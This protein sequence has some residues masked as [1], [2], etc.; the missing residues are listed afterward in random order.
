MRRTSPSLSFDPVS[1]QVL[2]A[3]TDGKLK[4][5]AVPSG[6]LVAVY[7]D[8]AGGFFEFA[9][10]P[11]GNLI[12]TA[13]ADGLVKLWS[14]ETGALLH[15]LEGHKDRLRTVVFS[16]DGR[17][18]ASGGDD[19]RITLWDVSTLEPVQTLELEGQVDALAFSADGL[20][21]ASGGRFIESVRL[22]D[23]STGQKKGVL[24]S[25]DV[26]VTYLAYSPDNRYL[27]GA[28][29]DGRTILWEVETGKAAH[30]LEGQ[31]GRG[32]PVVFSADG[33]YFATVD[34]YDD[35]YYLW[36]AE[37][38][39]LR[40]TFQGAG[41]AFVAVSLN[42]DGSLLAGGISPTDLNDPNQVGVWDTS[43]GQ[44]VT[45][46]GNLPIGNLL[47]EFSPDGR[48]IA[49]LVPFNLIQLWEVGTEG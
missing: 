48:R 35:R 29:R 10:H 28:T 32:R 2:S 13:G 1:G 44:L 31:G 25:A 24:G 16:P 19:G 43:S 30:T 33:A 22:W 8:Y 45:K 37:T 14:A 41:G 40:N 46:V 47:V 20:T 12:A 49:L 15:T 9:Y 38:G 17:L 36:D 3:G 42:R 21:L 4:Q 6:E 11:D 26:G 27:A 23:P 5:W 39:Q 34:D 7:N 18:L